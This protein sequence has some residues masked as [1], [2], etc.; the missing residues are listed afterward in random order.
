MKKWHKEIIG[1]I[2]FCVGLLVLY[3]LAGTSDFDAARGTQTLSIGKLI[4]YA[5]GGL[6]IMFAGVKFCNSANKKRRR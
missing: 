1:A 2:L 6:G 4:I 5:V 3:G